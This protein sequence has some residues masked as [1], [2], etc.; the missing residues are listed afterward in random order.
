MEGSGRGR[1]AEEKGLLRD[2]K[3]LGHR[4]TQKLGWSAFLM[5]AVGQ[6]RLRGREGVEKF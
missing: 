6:T 2:R 4:N 3:H 1:I 5:L